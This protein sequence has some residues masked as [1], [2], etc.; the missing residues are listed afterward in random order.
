MSYSNLH[1]VEWVCLA[2]PCPQAFT[3]LI[4]AFTSLIP[5]LSPV[6]SQSLTGLIPRLLSVSFQGFHW[7][8]SK[9]FICLIPRLSLVSSQS[10]TNL[11]PR[12][13][14]VSFQSNDQKRSKTVWRHALGNKACEMVFWISNYHTPNSREY[15]DSVGKPYSCMQFIK[16]RI[17]Y[18]KSHENPYQV[19]Q[20]T[21]AMS[22]R[23]M[24]S[25]ESSP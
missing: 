3:C 13:S 25:Y 12:F 5:R 20:V 19:L 9:A 4:P 21:C 16:S 6:S 22:E 7:S 15:L 2:Y 18:Y 17:F 24:K 14:P 23:A 8:H 10:L 1:G 11:I